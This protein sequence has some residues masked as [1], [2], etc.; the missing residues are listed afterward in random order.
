[1]S[2]HCFWLHRLSPPETSPYDIPADK[3]YTLF[4]A[5]AGS[6]ITQ[7]GAGADAQGAL[8]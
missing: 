2:R 7:A 5:P 1:M 3:V 8:A 6:R 4:F